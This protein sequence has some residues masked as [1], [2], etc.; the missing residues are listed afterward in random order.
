MNFGL[1]DVTCRDGPDLTSPK[2]YTGTFKQRANEK[3]S[4]RYAQHTKTHTHTHI[5]TNVFDTRFKN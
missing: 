5:H 1:N 4:E 2:H 3:K